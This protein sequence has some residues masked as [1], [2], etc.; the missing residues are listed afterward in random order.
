MF[1]SQLVLAITWHG[2]RRK[3]EAAGVCAL[4]GDVGQI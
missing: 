4:Y 1:E 2:S 3:V